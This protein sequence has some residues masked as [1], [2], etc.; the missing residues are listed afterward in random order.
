MDEELQRYR[1]EQADAWLTKVR[2]LVA[3]EKALVEAARTQFE[4]ADGLR[5]LDYSR[6][7]V[8][9]SP[10]PDAIP[11]A[12]IAHDEAGDSLASIAESAGERIRQ[13]AEAL[14]K[15]DDPTEAAA[16]TLY[17]VACRKWE[18]VC[19]E[20]DYSWDGMMKLRRRALN[21]AYDVMPHYEKDAIPTAF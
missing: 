21:S 19:V 4:M 15:M 2:R 1:I 16:L 13:A 8:T 10:T 3:Y 7:Q 6:I 17:Y 20:M 11:D 12:V 5:G 14:A 9:T 18:Q